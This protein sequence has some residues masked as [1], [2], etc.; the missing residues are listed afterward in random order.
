MGPPALHLFSLID[1]LYRNRKSLTTILQ[2]H[3]KDHSADYTLFIAAE[4]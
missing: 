1:I 4:G 3:V 2:A